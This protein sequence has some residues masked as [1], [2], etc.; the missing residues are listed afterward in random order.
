MHMNAGERTIYLQFCSSK[1]RLR[2]KRMYQ[3]HCE[4]LR[5]LGQDH[6]AKAYGIARNAALNRLSYFHVVDGLPP[7]VMYD[8]LEGAVNCEV[9]IMLK[10]FIYDKELFTL[11]RLND[12]MKSFK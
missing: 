11:T 4:K 5:V 10:T 9:K 8:L 12:R 2:T 7:D 1:F 6:A 3:S